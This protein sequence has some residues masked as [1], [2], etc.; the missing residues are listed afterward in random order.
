MTTMTEQIQRT[1]NTETNGYVTEIT[2]QVTVNSI[3][4]V[5]D[6]GDPSFNIRPRGQSKRKWARSSAAG[7]A[8]FYF[9]NCTCGK[10]TGNMYC[11]KQYNM[12]LRLH[13]KKCLKN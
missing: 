11:K 2:N 5:A 12:W 4:D 13:K 9:F 1:T 6:I 7:G 3:D 8:D 10:S